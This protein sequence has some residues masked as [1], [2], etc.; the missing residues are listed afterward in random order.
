V[1]FRMIKSYSAILSS[2]SFEGCGIGDALQE[3]F[4]IY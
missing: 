4:R 2:T 1:P 3:S